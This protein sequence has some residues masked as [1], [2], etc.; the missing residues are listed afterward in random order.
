VRTFP[1]ESQPVDTPRLS[2]ADIQQLAAAQLS[3]GSRVGYALL[4]MASLTVAT[5]VASL[6]VTEPSL[7]TRTSVAFACIVSMALTW[8]GFAAWVLTRRR[9][10]LGTDRVL[11]TQ[12]ALSFSACAT[13]GMLSLG[14]WGGVGRPAYA[15]GILNSALFLIAASLFV[16]ARHRLNMLSRR[17]GE[18]ERH[19]SSS[20]R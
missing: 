2:V 11:A 15:A 3:L 6:W 14:Y 20:P 1:S 13:V 4:L 12:I 16:R 19:F 7:P 8:S 18:L 9:V 5:G 17:R 10:L